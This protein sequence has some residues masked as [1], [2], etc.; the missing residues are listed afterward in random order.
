LFPDH[1]KTTE[2]LTHLRGGQLQHVGF[3]QEYQDA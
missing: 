1:P 3:G 2:L